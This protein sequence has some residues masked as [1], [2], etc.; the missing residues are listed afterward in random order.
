MK[1]LNPSKVN[2]E[3]QN[4][5]V[6]FNPRHKDK[7]LFIS[8]YPLLPKLNS[9]IWIASSGRK[10][11][12]WIA[13]SKS[14]ILTSAK[15]VNKHLEI[16]AKDIWGV[17]LPVFHIAGLSILARSY[18]SQNP[19]YFYNQK[20]KAD[21]F[22]SFL[23]NYKIT[24]CSLVPTQV[25]DLVKSAYSC[26]SSLRIVLVGGANLSFVLYQKARKLNWPILP[27]YGLTECSSQVATARLDSLNATFTQKILQD[28][29]LKEN[30]SFQQKN[31]FQKIAPL[32]ILS[33]VKAQI[34]KKQIYINSKSL[35][36]GFIS[37]DPNQ[38]TKFQEQKNTW[39]LTGDRGSIFTYKKQRFLKIDQSSTI[40]I[41][42]E[43]I[44][45]SSLKEIWMSLL[46][47]KGISQT[48]I[49]LPLEQERDGFSL[50]LVWVKP[51][52]AKCL[53][54][55]EEF[56]QSVSPFERITQVYFLPKWPFTDTL[57]TKK[58]EILKNLGF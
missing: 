45:L 53:S 50:A 36:S 18:L 16:C 49:L 20:W 47:K 35:M 42:G 14:A 40:Q 11:Q 52:S 24:V 31:L 26:P 13:L 23:K 21:S 8:Y 2:W 33:H 57:K 22:M 38:K 4:S 41:K 6:F 44:N 10:K 34:R 54:A 55:I 15:S 32:Q 12:K 27:T 3:N 19:C 28:F 29:S 39:Y 25:Y 7:N 1:T 43:K 17:S 5:Y 30:K 51:I 58:T 46:F 56:N 9:H 48:S 37:L